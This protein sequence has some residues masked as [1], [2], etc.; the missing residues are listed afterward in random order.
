M[1]DPQKTITTPGWCPTGRGSP[2]PAQSGT[3]WK[4]YAAGGNVASGGFFV[5]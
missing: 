4:R 3:R 2:D 1:W 5:P